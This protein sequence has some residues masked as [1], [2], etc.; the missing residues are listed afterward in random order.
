MYY[1]CKFGILNFYRFWLMTIYVHLNNQKL[2]I[3]LSLYIEYLK[4]IQI[5]IT[6]SIFV[7]R[8]NF[9]EMLHTVM[10]CKTWEIDDQSS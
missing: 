10:H 9:S 4:Q 5:Y 2:M 7:L 8:N 3:F 6:S 1:S